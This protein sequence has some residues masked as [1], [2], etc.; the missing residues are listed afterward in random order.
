MRALTSVEI[1]TKKTS[2]Y[3][4]NLNCTR[5]VPHCDKINN[6]DNFKP[7]FMLSNTLGTRCT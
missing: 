7:I 3:N 6:N 2:F 1:T 4:N 5:L